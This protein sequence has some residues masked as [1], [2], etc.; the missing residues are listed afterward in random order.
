MRPDF[1]STS[2]VQ[3]PGDGGPSSAVPALAPRMFVGNF[4]PASSIQPVFADPARPSQAQNFLRSRDIFELDPDPSG[5]RTVA[6]GSRSGQPYD[7]GF[8]AG[9]NVFGRI[10]D[11]DQLLETPEGRQLLQIA[12]RQRLGVRRDFLEAVSDWSWGDAPFVGL[13]ATVGGSLSDAK[14][15]SDTF[16]KLQD[17]QPVTDEELLKTRLFLAKQDY[18]TQGTFGSKVGDII[19]QAPGFAVEI[20]TTSGLWGAAR[21]ATAKGVGLATKAGTHLAVGSGVKR[22]GVELAEEGLKELAIKKTGETASKAAVRGAVGETVRGLTGLERKRFTVQLAKSLEDQISQDLSRTFGKKFADSVTDRTIKVMAHNLAQSSVSRVTAKLGASNSFSRFSHGLGQA[23]MDWTTRGLLD[24]GRFGTPTSTVLFSKHNSAGRALVDAFGVFFVEAPIKGSL[25]FGTNYLAT[26]ATAKAFGYDLVSEA[27]LSV[28]STALATHNKKLMDDAEAIALGMNLFEYVSENAG[29]GFS[30]LFRSVGLATGMSRVVP[31]AYVGELGGV[32]ME[33]KN[34]E[35]G[36][37]IRSLIRKALP[38]LE[39]MTQ[40]NG[41]LR[42]AAVKNT[43]ARAGHSVDD[44]VVGRI[45]AGDL[46]GVDAAVRATIGRDVGRFVRRAV[47]EETAAQ[48]EQQAF[49]QFARFVCGDY[50]VRHQLGPDQLVNAFQ[51]LGYDGIIEEMMEERYNDFAKGLFGFDVKGHKDFSDRLGQAFRNIWM[52]P[53]GELDWDQV[54]AE[55]IGFAV[56]AV[57]RAGAV[58]LQHMLGGSSELDLV[59]QTARAVQE[60]LRAMDVVEM[61]QGDYLDAVEAS[62]SKLHQQETDLNRQRNEILQAAAAN[63]ITDAEELSRLT[64]DVDEQLKTIPLRVTAQEEARRRVFQANGIEDFAKANREAMFFAPVLDTSVQAGDVARDKLRTDLSSEQIGVAAGEKIAAIENAWRIGRAQYLALGSESDWHAPWYRRFAMKA[65]GLAAAFITGE[66][67]LAFRNYAGW[68]AAD[69]GLDPHIA[70]QLLAVYQE[71]RASTINQMR[72]EPGDKQHQISEDAVWSR[73]EADYKKRASQV[74]AN[75]FAVANARMFS[76]TEMVDQAVLHLARRAGWSFSPEDRV[77]VRKGADGTRES[78]SFESFRQDHEAEVEVLRKDIADATFRLLAD[79]S[80]EERLDRHGAPYALASL[81]ASAPEAE[82]TAYALA[83]NL[84]GFGNVVSVRELDGSTTLEQAVAAG[85]KQVLRPFTQRIVAALGS[86]TEVNYDAPAERDILEVASILGYPVKLGTDEELKELRRNVVDIARQLEG[87]TN[88]DSVLSFSAEVN[89]PENSRLYGKPAVTVTA[90]RRGD[91]RWYASLEDTTGQ[92]PDG[93]VRFSAP[94][95]EAMRAEME[96]RGLRQVDQGVV[97]TGV[98]KVVANDPFLLI[99]QLGLA[100]ELLRRTLGTDAASLDWSKTHPALRKDAAGYIYQTPEEWKH[101]LVTEAVAAGL[102]SR[103]GTDISRY[104]G[105]DAAARQVSYESAKRTYDNMYGEGGYMKVMD[106]LLRDA[107][108]VVP[109]GS[110]GTASFVLGLSDKYV[111][112]VKMLRARRDSAVTFVTVDTLNG[113]DDSSAILLA[114]VEDAFVRHRSLIRARGPYHSVVTDFLK[115]LDVQAQRHLAAFGISQREARALEALRRDITCHANNPTR[116]SFAESVSALVLLMAERDRATGRLSSAHSLAYQVIASDVYQTPQFLRM[117]ALV[118]LMFGG[119]GFSFATAAQKIG[120]SKEGVPARGL[121]RVLGLFHREGAD[122]LRSFVSGFRPLGMSYANFVAEVNRQGQTLNLRP[123]TLAPQAEVQAGKPSSILNALR[124]AFAGAGFTDLTQVQTAFNALAKTRDRDLRAIFRDRAAEVDRLA[125]NLENAIQSQEAEIAQLRTE[126]V[127]LKEDLARSERLGLEREK[128]QERAAELEG[129]LE[130]RTRQLNE[131][132][133][134]L[135]NLQADQ[136]ESTPREETDVTRYEVQAA[137]N[138]GVAA[139]LG[140]MQDT[141]SPVLPGASEDLGSW[142]G[143]FDKE[144]NRFELSRDHLDYGSYWRLDT[145]AEGRAVLREDNATMLDLPDEACEYT[146]VALRNLAQVTQGTQDLQESAFSDLAYK[147]LPGLRQAELMRIFKFFRKQVNQRASLIRIGAQSGQTELDATDE[148]VHTENHQDF[149][150]KAL[151]EYEGKE[152][153]SLLTLFNIASPETGRDLQAILQELKSTV[154]MQLRELTP[155]AVQSDLRD[156]LS[157]LDRILNPRARVEADTQAYRD[158][159]KQIEDLQQTLNSADARAYERQLREWELQARTLA[160][161]QAKAKLELK[162]GAAGTERLTKIEK[163]IAEH[164]RRRPVRSATMNQIE[165]LRVKRASLLTANDREALWRNEMN[166]LD[167][168]HD[169]VSEYDRLVGTL[170]ARGTDGYLVNRKAAL[171]LSFLK[172]LDRPA[173]VRLMTLCANSAKCARVVADFESEQSSATAIPKMRMTADIGNYS[174]VSSRTITSAFADLK[175]LKSAADV[176]KI[177]VQLRAAALKMPT[178]FGKRAGLWLGANGDVLQSVFGRENSLVQILHSPEMRTYMRSVLSLGSESSRTYMRSTIDVVREAAKPLAGGPSSL[179]QSVIDLLEQYR[180]RVQAAHA[181]ERIDAKERELD[182]LSLAWFAYGLPSTNKNFAQGLTS[183]HKMASASTEWRRVLELFRAA[184]PVTVTSAKFIKG[185]SSKATSKVVVSSRG[186]IPLV[187]QWMDKPL[188][189][190]ESFAY[191]A[192]NFM[193]GAEGDRL[194]AMSDAD[195]LEQVLPECRQNMTWPDAGRTEVL[196]KNLTRDY[197]PM[198]VHQACTQSYEA[199]V[200]SA[201]YQDA[202]AAGLRWYVELFAG[203]HSGALLQLPRLAYRTVSDSGQAHLQG[204]F[205]TKADYETVST[206]MS[207]ALGM[208]KLGKDAKRATVSSAEIPGVAMR[209]CRR[210]NGTVE[211]GECRVHVL[212]NNSPDLAFAKHEALLGTVVGVGYALEEQRKIAGD[213][214]SQVLKLHYVDTT[215]EDITMFK[216]LTSTASAEGKGLDLEGSAVRVMQ[217]HLLKVRKSDADISTSIMMDKDALKVGI[218]NSKVMGVP[219]VDAGGAEKIRSLIDYIIERLR[220][221]DIPA[222]GLELAGLVPYLSDNADGLI[223]WATMNE[224]G[225]LVQTQKA[226]ADLFPEGAR[227]LPVEGLSGRAFDFSYVDNNLMSYTVANVSHESQPEVGRMA[228]NLMLDA[229]TMAASQNR[230]FSQ[231]LSEGAKASNKDLMDTI[232]NW[233]LLTTAIHTD[234]S[235]VDDARLGLGRSEAVA[236]LVEEK[237]ESPYSLLV[238]DQVTYDV[239]KKVTQS[240]NMP[241][242]MLACALE[243]EG[244]VFDDASGRV[245]AHS[246]DPFLE[247]CAQGSQVYGAEEAAWRRTSRSLGWGRINVRSDGFR[248]GWHL[249]RAKFAEVYGEEWLRADGRTLTEKLEQLVTDIRNLDL[250]HQQAK[251]AMVDYGGKTPEA[252]RDRSVMGSLLETYQI[253]STAARDAR[254]K[255]ASCFVDHYGQRISELKCQYSQRGGRKSRFAS[256]ANLYCHAV[257]FDDLFLAGDTTGERQFDRSAVHF[258]SAALRIGADAATKAKA[259]AMAQDNDPV[260]L[261]GT[262]FGFPRTPSYNG[263]MWAQVLRASIYASQDTAEDGTVVCGYDAKVKPDAQ[264]LKILGADHDG[265]KA[266]CYMYVV[267]TDTGVAA[268][269]DVPGI[270]GSDATEQLA[271]FDTDDTVR[272]DY[273][274]QAVLAGLVSPPSPRRVNGESTNRYRL[275]SEGQ[276]RISNKFVQGLFDL[277]RNTVINTPEESRPFYGTELARATKTRPVASDELWAQL[278]QTAGDAANYLKHSLLADTTTGAKVA[279][280]AKSSDAAR[281]QI[282]SLAGVLHVAQLSGRFDSL[283]QRGAS[284]RNWQ[285]WFNFIYGLDGISNATF[286]DIK[287]QI[288]RRLGWT[289]GMI[290]TV[291]V[292][293]MFSGDAAPTTEAEFFQALLD[294]VQSIANKGSRYYMM[295]ASEPAEGD[296]TFITIHRA[297]RG[298]FRGWDKARIAKHPGEYRQQVSPTDVITRA[299]VMQ[300]FGIVATRSRRGGL[301]YSFGLASNPHAASLVTRFKE[302]CTGSG[303]LYTEHA[304]CEALIRAAASRRGQTSGAGYVFWL[305]TKASPTREAAMDFMRWS[306]GQSLL[307]TARQFAGAVN[308]TKA[309]PADGTKLGNRAARDKVFQKVMKETA[310]SDTDAI[311]QTMN[312][313]TRAAYRVANLATLFGRGALAATNRAKALADLTD[314]LTQGTV[315]PPLRKLL[316]GLAVTPALSAYELLELQ[317]NIQTMPSTMAALLDMPSPRLGT[318]VFG[319][320]ELTWQTLDAIATTVGDYDANIEQVEDARAG[321]LR[322]LELRHGLESMVATL[323]AMVSSSLQGMQNVAFASLAMPGESGYVNKP[324]KSQANVVSAE[325]ESSGSFVRGAWLRRMVP[326]FMFKDAVGLELAQQ[327]MQDAMDGAFDSDRS[328]RTAQFKEGLS[329]TAGSFVLSLANLQALEQENVKASTQKR[330]RVVALAPDIAICRKIIRAIAEVQHIAPEEVQIQPSTILS[331]V[332]PLLATLTTRVG[333]D[334]SVLDLMPASVR[335]RLSEGQVRLYSGALER[336]EKPVPGFALMDVVTSTLLS[337]AG[338]G[339]QAPKVTYLN[340]LNNEDQFEVLNSLAMQAGEDQQ[341]ADP[342]AAESVIRMAEKAAGLPETGETLPPDKPRRAPEHHTLV[343]LLGPDEILRNLHEYA[344]QVLAPAVQHPKEMEDPP[345]PVEQADVKVT[346]SQGPSREVSRLA[347][348]I[349]ATIGHWAKVTADG[350]VITIRARN[351]LKGSGAARFAKDGVEMVLTVRVGA[352]DPSTVDTASLDYNSPAVAASFCEAA[353]VLGLTPEQFSRNLSYDERKALVEAFAGKGRSYA[354]SLPS[355]VRL[356]GKDMAVLAGEI[357]LAS[358]DTG[359]FYHELFH[360]MIGMFRAMDVFGEEDVKVFR[361]RYGEAP[362]GTGWLFNEEKAAEAFRRYAENR[363]RGQIVSDETEEVKGIF[364]RLWRAIKSFLQALVSGFSHVDESAVNYLF[365]MV[366]TGQAAMSNDKRADVDVLEAQEQFRGTFVR[367]LEDNTRFVIQEGASEE[368]AVGAA[369]ASLANRA[370][371]AAK[372]TRP[373][374][375]T[376]HTAEGSTETHKIPADTPAAARLSAMLQEELGQPRVRVRAVQALLRPLLQARG[377][378]QLP[379]A[380]EFSNTTAASKDVNDIL[381]WQ[382]GRLEEQSPISG[383]SEKAA[384]Y[385][386][387]EAL[388]RAAVRQLL[389]IAQP[390]DASILSRLATRKTWSELVQANQLLKEG[391]RERALARMKRR[392]GT[393]KQAVSHFLRM[394]G[395]PTTTAEAENEAYMALM[396]AAGWIYGKVKLSDLRR[397]FVQTSGDAAVRIRRGAMRISSA[398]YT[399]FLIATGPHDSR[400]YFDA[401]RSRLIKTRNDA[402]EASGGE[403]RV[404]NVAQFLLEKLA[405]LGA[406]SPTDVVSRSADWAEALDMFEREVMSGIRRGDFDEKLGDFGPYR[407][408]TAADSLTKN[409]DVDL[410]QR[411]QGIYQLGRNDDEADS[412]VQNMLKDVESTVFAITAS[413]RFARDLGVVPG[414]FVDAGFTANNP[415]PLDL[416]DVAEEFKLAQ[417]DMA[418]LDTKIIDRQCE[419]SFVLTN[420]DKWLEGS[421]PSRLGG[422][423]LRDLFMKSSAKLRG[424]VSQQT[425]VENFWANYLGLSRT[426]GRKLLK[427]I[428]HEGQFEM[429]EGFYRRRAKSGKYVGFDLYH[430]VVGKTSSEEFTEDEYRTVDM[431]AKALAVLANG[432][433]YYITGADGLHFDSSFKPVT[434]L[435]LTPELVQKRIQEFARYEERGVGASMT[436]ERRDDQGN[437]IDEA[438]VSGVAVSRPFMALDRL[439]QQLHPEALTQTDEGKGLHW[440]RRVA[441]AIYEALGQAHLERSKRLDAGESF[442]DEEFNDFVLARLEEAGVAVAV[443]NDDGVRTTATIAIPA[444]EIEQMF[445]DSS[446]YQKLIRAGRSAEMLDSKTI[447]AD[448]MKNYHELRREV[449]NHPWLTSGDAQFLNNFDTPLP[450]YQGTGLFMYHANRAVRN[451]KVESQVRLAKHEQTFANLC[452]S[453]RNLAKGVE[454]ITYAQLSMIHDYFNTPD[455][456]QALLTAIMEGQYAQ[457]KQKAESTGFVIDPVKG[458]W[459]DVAKQI[460]LK[461][462]ERFLMM[463]EGKSLTDIDDQGS[464]RRMTKMYEDMV[465]AGGTTLVGSV[466]MTDEQMYR[467]HGALPM[468]MQL[469]HKVHVAMKG[470]ADSLYRRSVLVNMM[471]TKTIDGQPVY[472]INPSKYGVETSGVPDEVWAAAAKWWTTFHPDLKYDAA[473]SGLENARDMYA[474]ISSK[475]QAGKGEL[476]GRQFQAMNPADLFGQRSVEGVLC[477]ADDPSDEHTSRMNTLGLAGEALGYAKHFFMADRMPGNAKLQL[478]DRVMAW[479]KSMSVMCSAFF[480][481][482][483]KWESPVAAVGALATIGSNLTPE[484]IRKHHDSLNAISKVLGGSAWMDENFIGFRDI[485]QMMDTNDPFLADLVMWAESMGITMSTTLNNPGEPSKGY[486]ARDIQYIK[487][488]IREAGFGAENASKVGAVLEAAFLRSGE[489]AF[490]Y[491]L[492]ATKLAVTCQIAMKLRA[493]AKRAGRA[494]DPIRDLGKYAAYIDTEIGGINPL[495]YA[496]MHPQ[497]RA[498]WNRVLFSWQW[499]RSAWEAGGGHFFEDLMFG[500]HTINKETRKYLIGRWMRMYGVVMIGVPMLM[501][502]LIKALAVAAGHD[503]P[504][505]KWFTWQNEDKTRWTAYDLTPL[506]KVVHAHEASARILAGLAGAAYGYHKNGGLGAT[507]GALVGAMG[508]P[509]YT[510]KDEANSTTR[511]RRYYG[512][513][514][515]QGWEFFRWFDDPASQFFAK[516][517]MP[518][519]RLLEGVCGRNLAYLD[520]ELPL[521]SADLP[522]RWLTLGS[523]SAWNNMFRAFMPFTVNAWNTFGDAGIAAYFGPVQMGASRT[524]IEKR[525]V[526]ALA[527]WAE[528]DRAGYRYGQTIG[529]RRGKAFRRELVA[530]ILEDARRNGNADPEQLLTAA[531]GQLTPRYYSK[532]EKLLPDRPE[533]P[534]DEKEIR[535]TCRS[536]LR[537]GATFDRAQMSLTRRLKERG[538]QIKDIPEDLRDAQRQAVREGFRNPYGY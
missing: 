336:S 113:Q 411:N 1:F 210:Q 106:N 312:V 418:D 403:N 217:D 427:L 4:S 142:F 78:K 481:I 293:L 320:R 83:L 200:S 96:K 527:K 226:L 160:E 382:V 386:A 234:Q 193:P 32:L 446:A 526:T 207:I 215:G 182:K 15:V 90:I 124:A 115:L 402:F 514:G 77:F 344:D 245:G 356:T 431:Y 30:N 266:A 11:R 364:E 497:M 114:A 216:G 252:R 444:Q 475:L 499:T 98:D 243:S 332:V 322:T 178:N 387:E 235:A 390:E 373:D 259:A 202:E 99:Q 456:G 537:L 451:F 265:D 351:G 416:V 531:I 58:R 370:A 388:G 524:N 468:N 128:L 447:I 350:D 262:A 141:A 209:G 44:V 67:A 395:A 136:G 319:D 338:Y 109:G 21:A 324:R 75:Y 493:E 525:L 391:V 404:F 263:A 439:I 396:A 68:A 285:S 36:G 181:W 397:G 158:L 272:R 484:T 379:A 61:R 165:A 467:L 54:A 371:L 130:E 8:V 85:S 157:Y 46:G 459:L 292:D 340:R 26:S 59:R 533:D 477:V 280:S 463:A 334:R 437:V 353:K 452:A 295:A 518:T 154:A 326:A 508:V 473:K 287:E 281:A 466:G 225:Q 204:Y 298:M 321:H 510:G 70:N 219:Y 357:K 479:S 282:V 131:A 244:A 458:I 374:M 19:R 284:T 349:R 511:N 14:M 419:P 462:Q 179:I 133:K 289:Q 286:D 465:S 197:S 151:A 307:D 184:Q 480:P 125:A 208:L 316:S 331:Q 310:P 146:A 489:K 220:D 60:G 187:A 191:I 246:A 300:F 363:A 183:G 186:V 248:Y 2:S 104:P 31:R 400:Y 352:G 100:R 469:G 239:L 89:D 53:G 294:Y 270:S 429:A 189:D 470:I 47:K 355:I 268:V 297:I 267:D 213:P 49:R 423:P 376:G 247:Y 450:F 238:E 464:L 476:A 249:D 229:A 276:S 407:H 230:Y 147:L 308:Y 362:A 482:A 232:A 507:V 196:A 39:N 372:M 440:F 135:A 309:D 488:R 129:Q 188:T 277:V 269:Q 153:A 23:M 303:A 500:G 195:F 498:L 155:I 478:L 401:L 428:E 495:R 233:G 28:E 503:D 360:S 148:G 50:M 172:G 224:K 134:R 228:R 138:A 441:T 534:V 505:D 212:I 3:E 306:T 323:Y 311:L 73:M 45:L 314:S 394:S 41:R 103:Y 415:P 214:R 55:A 460:Y 76:Q 51:R 339:L 538:V 445:K 231:R 283:F 92:A 279:A 406:F 170:M 241:V 38:S 171:L 150:D 410:R 398:Q 177:V 513:F 413:I 166:R 420:L 174:S 79:N 65:A 399:G 422:L 315:T 194:R 250:A 487:D 369:Q 139:D 255:F 492:N 328:V 169:G 144:A 72:Q 455:E 237:G 491:A 159:T 64:K 140:P 43:L 185:H 333:S 29:A 317:A 10:M 80:L 164:G 472:Y 365:D 448:V 261:A 486:V 251:Q 483:T 519:Q 94:T 74:M 137:V 504:D 521:S 222:Q 474:I 175:T 501:Q 25:Q 330:D 457:G 442:T 57:T 127:K 149:G 201:E 327:A 302:L 69:E 443:R 167:E 325:E 380:V 40:Q 35:A 329:T 342:L 111:V 256:P 82:R 506:M 378:R 273:L 9:L 203:E 260:F 52:G 56:P 288:C 6:W 105:E 199:M 81:P 66:P 227:V 13:F 112:P 454:D 368:Q 304:I 253:A 535:R 180:D 102:Y 496:W 409:E 348:T 290:D 412:P 434:F 299:Q 275:T 313:A 389:N 517:S 91:G 120:A 5:K 523:K 22:L 271:R 381:S 192:K 223:P 33:A 126:Q 242:N 42:A 408:T 108:V 198:A 393:I 206:K 377:A 152:L 95:A 118:D 433:R 366:L 97:V 424:F 461:Q 421:L 37:F 168:I 435:G 7:E 318:S 143:S 361:A 34:T 161:E 190:K 385:G 254:L 116:R 24:Q 12:E 520:R 27:Q 16:H 375:F 516:L 359:T 528:N 383:A 471:F 93:L 530:D 343:D 532:L 430:G 84:S 335:R 71:M 485:V 426:E 257:S 301:S 88:R 417:G 221:V 48:G 132:H 117:F 156:A 101:Q 20:A 122:Y 62:I 119:D 494:F 509:N 405:P 515:K 346:P 240:L 358:A 18:D 264:S 502:I 17:G 278:V 305:V 425:N 436:R 432:G 438:F 449:R 341:G 123:K 218:L 236:T 258:G 176:D 205:D 296:A 522:E 347:R 354:M 121:E 110:N 86:G 291:V 490:T 512:H 392:E 173:R 107:G 63:N 536:L 384:I 274:R 211:F 529:K 337:S 453:E 367:H 87:V 345:V 163:Q 162:R 145:D 414:S